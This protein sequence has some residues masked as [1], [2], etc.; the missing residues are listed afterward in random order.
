VGPG[1]GGGG[2][3]GSGGGGSAGLTLIRLCAPLR[4]VPCGCCIYITYF[5][6]FVQL[7]GVM[8]NCDF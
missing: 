4:K 5:I 7:L 8:V 3:G 1:S 2:D 6:Y